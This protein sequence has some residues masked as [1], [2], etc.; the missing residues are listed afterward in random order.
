MLLLQLPW[1]EAMIEIC[2]LNQA[3]VTRIYNGAEKD[4]EKF[5]HFDYSP[6][7]T[8]QKTKSIWSLTLDST[9]SVYVAES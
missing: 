9:L 7:I 1:F 4:A 8:E 3:C 6:H 5:R 2:L